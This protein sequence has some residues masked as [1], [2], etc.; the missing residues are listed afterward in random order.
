MALLRMFGLCMY[1]E[2]LVIAVFMIVVRAQQTVTPSGTCPTEECNVNYRAQLEEVNQALKAAVDQVNRTLAEQKILINK[3]KTCGNNNTQITTPTMPN[4]NNN[5]ARPIT[6]TPTTPSINNTQPEYIAEKVASLE[7]CQP[8][9]G[10]ASSVQGVALLEGV[11]FVICQNSPDMRAYEASTFKPLP[12]MTLP[13]AGV[14]DKYPNYIVANRFEK[15]LY[16]GVLS[17]DP[18]SLTF[19]KGHDIWRMDMSL[20]WVQLSTAQKDP[21]FNIFRLRVARNGQMMYANS[22]H[23]LFP[24]SPTTYSR[25]IEFAKRP[26]APDEYIKGLVETKNGSF[27]IYSEIEDYLLRVNA[28][29]DYVGK[30]ADGPVIPTNNNLSS[31]NDLE[32]GPEDMLLIAEASKNRILIVDQEKNRMSELIREDLNGTRT[33]NLWGPYYLSFDIQSQLLVV[34]E[35]PERS[36]RTAASDENSVKIFRITKPKA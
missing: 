31:I 17:R 2:L 19:Y 14:K 5:T 7:P 26:L 3:W 1:N 20:Q 25:A 33:M 21:T 34:G 11:I 6:P 30:L 10:P 24:Q 28:N 9:T 18:Q 23:I 29:G 27:I 36:A 13:I 4:N 15:T 16:L 32:Q 22:T 12:N 35:F 8:M